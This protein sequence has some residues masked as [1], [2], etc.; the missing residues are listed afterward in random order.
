MS[1]DGGRIPSYCQFI[2]QH[3]LLAQIPTS[4]QPHVSMGHSFLLLISF[5]FPLS[6]WKR[7]LA[8]CGAAGALGANLRC[9]ACRLGSQGGGG[10]SLEFVLLALARASRGIDQC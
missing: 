4:Q 2:L 6:W 9:R 1:G 3:A 10:V 7:W 8:A 5:F